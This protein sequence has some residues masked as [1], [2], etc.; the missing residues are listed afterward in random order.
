MI[1][2]LKLLLIIRIK[3]NDALEI[4]SEALKYGKIIQNPCKNI[5]NYIGDIDFIVVNY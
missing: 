4:D 2:K 5:I 1:K 3:K